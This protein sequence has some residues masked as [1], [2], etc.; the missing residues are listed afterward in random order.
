MALARKADRS[1]VYH[2]SSREFQAAIAEITFNQLMS[3]LERLAQTRGRSIH[4]VVESMNYAWIS[5][6]VGL[7]YL[8]VWKDYRTIDTPECLSPRVQALLG[9]CRNGNEAASSF[10]IAEAIFPLGAFDVVDLLIL[11][12]KDGSRVIVVQSIVRYG[13]ALLWFPQSF[14]YT[15]M[16]SVQ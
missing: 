7:E 1:E 11:L 15:L 9:Q 12:R 5:E 4:E 3:K 10:R 6:H 14:D 13:Q 8:E 2:H 16:I